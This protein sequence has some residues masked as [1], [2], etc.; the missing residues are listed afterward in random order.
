MYLV[1]KHGVG[2]I[3]DQMAYTCVTIDLYMYD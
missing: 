3:H 2:N 1:A